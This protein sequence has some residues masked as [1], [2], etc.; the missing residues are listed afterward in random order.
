MYLEFSVQK[1]IVEEGIK[2]DSEIGFNLYSLSLL[3]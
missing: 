3:S 2:K 1:N